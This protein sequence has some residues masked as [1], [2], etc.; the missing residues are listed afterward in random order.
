[1]TGVGTHFTLLR[2]GDMFRRRII[3]CVVA[4]NFIG[5]PVFAG[6]GGAVAATKTVRI[7]PQSLQTILLAQ[8]INLL[9]ELNN[10]YKAKVTVDIARAQ[11]LPSL[12]LGAGANGGGFFLASAVFLL[13]FLLPGS[14][15][16]VRESQQLLNAEV[17][18]YYILQLNEYAA[19]FSLYMTIVGD[20]ALRDVLYSQYKN[21][22]DI[23]NNVELAVKLGLRPTTDLYS[24][25]AQTAMMQ[26]QVRQFE[27]LI[28]QERASIRQMLGLDLSVDIRFDL[29]HL[30][31]VDN[32]ENSQAK[33]L[34][35]VVL[36]KSPEIAQIEAL[37]QA[38]KSD[39]WIKIFSFINSATVSAQVS[40]QGPGVSFGTVVGQGNFNF[41][42][43][44]FPNITLSNLNI[45]DMYLRRRAVVQEQARILESALSS[46]RSAKL[47]LASATTAESNFKKAYDA[48]LTQY[49]LGTTDLLHVLT[50][51]NSLAQASVTRLQAQ[52][53]LDSQRVTLNR[54]LIL[55]KFADIRACKVSQ[56]GGGGLVDRIVRPN[57]LVPLM[58]LCRAKN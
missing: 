39:K 44:Y 26:T 45:Q 31:Q 14:W 27:E 7:N 8:N 25:Q 55:D 6:D 5:Q 30:D 2:G 46:V 50:A 13:P 58:E 1:L 10:V 29:F 19:A 22:L 40:G 43:S 4:L 17:K 48:Y 15:I 52:I 38:A 51:A 12:N 32:L 3:P 20:F 53:D 34:L 57:K 18:S 47:Q 9:Q 23:Q 21:L 56:I 11:V 24:A 28:A 41:G 16:N 37:I 35:P 54:S 33:D 36:K 49:T 42:F